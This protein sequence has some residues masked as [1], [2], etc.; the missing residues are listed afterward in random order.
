MNGKTFPSGIEN[1]LGWIS[2][3]DEREQDNCLTGK[4][5]Y[6]IL[7]SVVAPEGSSEFQTNTSLILA[8][9]KYH[10]NTLLVLA[11]TNTPRN[12]K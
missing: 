10:T 6:L 8:P 12:R 1:S 11:P 5:Y 2:V 9:P 3:K 7:K 4:D